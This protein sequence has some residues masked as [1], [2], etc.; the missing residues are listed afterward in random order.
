MTSFYKTELGKY[1]YDISLKAEAGKLSLDEVQTIYE[2]IA[3]VENIDL[4]I[5]TLNEVEI[6]KYITMGI[7]VYNILLKE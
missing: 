2:A 6:K 5:T 3:K 4:D 7:Y 1:L